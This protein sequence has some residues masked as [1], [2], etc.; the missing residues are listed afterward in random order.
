MAF[1]SLLPHTYRGRNGIYVVVDRLTKM[2]RLAATKPECTAS[3]VAVL[4]DAHAYRNHG[5][6]KDVVR[7]REPVFCSKYWRAL[8]DIL[9]IYIRASSAYHPQTDGK[10][11]ITNENVET[12]LR[13]FVNQ[14]QRNENLYL[15]DV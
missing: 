3:S 7:D 1:I 13:N 6:L 8:T 2:I 10:T 12:L 5:L 4:F 9:K 14:N 15:V 11:Q